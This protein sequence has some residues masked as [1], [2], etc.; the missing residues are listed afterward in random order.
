VYWSRDLNHWDA[1]YKAVVLDRKNCKWS[2]SCIGLP[3]V[4]KSGKRLA[5]LYDAPGDESVSHMQRD[6]GLAWL[7]LPLVAPPK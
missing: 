4:V 3:S 6:V 7:N 1:R 2:K 5:V